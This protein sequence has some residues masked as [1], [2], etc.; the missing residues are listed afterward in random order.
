MSTRACHRL[1]RE[2]YCA[3]TYR[4]LWQSLLRSRAATGPTHNRRIFT[5]LPT[6]FRYRQF[7]QFDM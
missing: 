7:L 6:T 4:K 2:A 1:E 3:R 5:G